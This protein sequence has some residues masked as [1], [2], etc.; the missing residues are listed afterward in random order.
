M[1]VTNRVYSA[2]LSSFRFSI[3][4][5]KLHDYTELG[6]Y[7]ETLQGNAGGI[8]ATINKQ[9]PAALST[10]ADYGTNIRRELAS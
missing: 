8:G 9:A 7:S 1:F 3:N 10:G 4:H 6:D 2:P 5:Y